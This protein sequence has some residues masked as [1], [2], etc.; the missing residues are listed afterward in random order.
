MLIIQ[1]LQIESNQELDS[2]ENIHGRATTSR[3]KRLE[4]TR[5][6]LKGDEAGLQARGIDD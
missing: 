5:F 2:R 3:S 4:M 1:W 6:D